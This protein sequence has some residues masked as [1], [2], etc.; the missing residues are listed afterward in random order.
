MDWCLIAYQIHHFP[1]VRSVRFN[2]NNICRLRRIV[3]TASRSSTSVSNEIHF[4]DHQKDT[5]VEDDNRRYTSST[6]EQSFGSLAK[7]GRCQ[8]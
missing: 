3:D 4:S 7:K 1:G 8:G 5:P 6:L 2:G